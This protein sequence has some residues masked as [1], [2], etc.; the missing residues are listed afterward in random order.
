MAS[1]LDYYNKNAKAYALSTVECKMDEAISIFLNEIKAP[2]A[3][4]LDFGCGSGRDSKVFLDKGYAVDSV[5]GS[6]EMCQEAEK[7]L[8]HPVTHMF[9]SDL[10]EVDS[11]DGIWACAS[12]LH[13]PYNKLRN[14][15]LKMERALRKGGVVYASF[16]YGDMEGVRGE[17]YF[18]DMNEEKLA[19]LLKDTRLDIIKT[20]I[21][22]DVRLDRAGDKWFNILLRKA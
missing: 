2:E 9:F 17:R 21:S 13:L 6:L 4:I 3:V 12:I 15:I 18:T 10:S 20:W 5:D 22:N 19:S 16:R 1:T 8:S 7:F 14:V 11:Y